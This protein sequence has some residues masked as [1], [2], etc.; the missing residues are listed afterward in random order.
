MDAHGTLAPSTPGRYAMRHGQGED[1]F[2]RT[3]SPARSSP[4][5]ATTQFPRSSSSFG[6]LQVSNDNMQGPRRLSGPSRP[7]AINPE[8]AALMARVQSVSTKADALLAHSRRPESRMRSAPQRAE[9]Q[10]RNAMQFNLLGSRGAQPAINGP[11]TDRRGAP[12]GVHTSVRLMDLTD[13]LARLETL[14]DEVAVLGHLRPG[15]ARAAAHEAAPR[16]S[17]GHSLR[18]G[19]TGSGAGDA[20]PGPPG[21]MYVP[22]GVPTGMPPTVALV[23]YPPQSSRA[24]SFRSSPGTDGGTPNVALFTPSMPPPGVPIMSVPQ[25]PDGLVQVP[26]A[27]VHGPTPRSQGRFIEI[28]SANTPGIPPATPPVPF[29][30]GMAGMFSPAVP[31]PSF[32]NRPTVPT[33]LPWHPTGAPPPLGFW[34]GEA[35]PRGYMTP[36]SSSRATRPS[37]GGYG[38]ARTDPEMQ[39][40]IAGPHGEPMRSFSAPRQQSVPP[41]AVIAAAPLQQLGPPILGTGASTPGMPP[42]PGLWMPSLGQLLQDNVDTKIR[43]WLRTIPIGNGADRGWDDAQI[44]EIARFAQD[45]HLEHLAAEDIYKRYVEHQVESAVSRE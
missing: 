23:G 16:S 8:T 15:T 43:R 42:P 38:T 44:A 17:R 1:A 39:R 9:S 40:G 32:P 24:Q 28:A 21:G 33:V 45:Q 36:R 19:S 29:P 37:V 3:R 41:V 35:T 11:P 20:T 14:L 26:A 34:P 10:M 7:A 22:P 27:K 4:N 12:R 6:Q 5:G 25:E 2:T 13:R 30:P 18:L 31:T